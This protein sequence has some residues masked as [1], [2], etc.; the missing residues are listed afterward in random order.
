MIIPTAPALLRSRSKH[1]LEAIAGRITK[2]IP[3]ENSICAGKLF[4]LEKGWLSIEQVIRITAELKNHPMK[5]FIV[6]P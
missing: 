6:T 1:G 4:S 2:R 3:G 5:F